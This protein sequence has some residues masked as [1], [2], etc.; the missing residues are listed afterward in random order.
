MIKYEGVTSWVM[1]KV[2]WLTYNNFWLT[3]TNWTWHVFFSYSN[4]LLQFYNQK[5]TLPTLHQTDSW[6]WLH[7]NSPKKKPTT[8]NKMIIIILTL[9]KFSYLIWQHSQYPRFFSCNLFLSALRL[10]SPAV[11]ILTG[12]IIPALSLFLIFLKTTATWY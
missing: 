3:K 12:P 7:C 8:L 1:V 4:L 2:R 5:L 11:T 6:V 10:I 9:S